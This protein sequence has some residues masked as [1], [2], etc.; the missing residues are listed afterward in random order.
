MSKA[1]SHNGYEIRADA[2]QKPSGRWYP[3]YKFWNPA[4]KLLIILASE[5]ANPDFSTE[6]EA[7][8][9]GLEQAKQRIEQKSAARGALASY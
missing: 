9:H 4:A 1:V 7:L 2:R 6:V 8:E 5:I 3:A